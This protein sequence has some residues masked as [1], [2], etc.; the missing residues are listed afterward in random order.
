MQT[1]KISLY[2]FSSTKTKN[3][4]CVHTHTQTH[5]HTSHTY[6]TQ[7]SHESKRTSFLPHITS[8]S[9]LGSTFSFTL[10]STY[11]VVGMHWILHLLIHRLKVNPSLRIKLMTNVK[12]FL[13]YARKSKGLKKS[14]FLSTIKYYNIYYTALIL[15]QSTFK[16]KNYFILS[17][18]LD[19]CLPNTIN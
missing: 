4:L 14:H 10:D 13:N 16:W 9:S 17:L 15:L 11:H 8:V 2:C 19:F 1:F 7:K 18:K 5:K 6:T 3:T 12:L